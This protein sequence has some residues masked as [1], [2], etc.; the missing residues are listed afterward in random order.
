MPCRNS[1]A[2]IRAALNS[3]A[4]GDIRKEIIIVDDAS[5]DETVSIVRSM[6]LPNLR[7]VSLDRQMG[8][9]PALSQGLALASGKYIARMDA[10][11]IS[12][13]ERLPKQLK[14]LRETGA[15]ICFCRYADHNPKT[16]N[17]I[18]W[19]ELP[20]PLL[21]WRSLFENPYGPHSGSMF[22]RSAIQDAGSYD[23]FFASAQDY[24]LWDRCAAMG[25]GFVYA[26]EILL[27]RVTGPDSITVQK[28][29][30][31]LRFAQIVSQRAMKR[32]FPAA[33]EPSLSALLWLMTGRGAMPTSTPEMIGWCLSAISDFLCRYVLPDNQPMIWR[34]AALHLARRLKHFPAARRS[35]I[36]LAMFKAAFRSKRP[37]TMAMA[38][39]TSLQPET[40]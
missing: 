21:A 20:P 16:G 11:D 1:S 15:K 19:N 14:L 27:Q 7:I 10:D 28:N 23:S 6:N 22:E 38:L 36:R 37:R 25:Y 32:V 3:V 13:P 26:P 4:D 18:V 34:D 35:E 17:R 9:T 24:D 2:T 31:Q 8:I 39:L 29:E 40:V 12:L 5:T 30:T 33:T